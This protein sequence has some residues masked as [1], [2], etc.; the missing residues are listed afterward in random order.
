MK[1]ILI[2]LLV[3]LL[4]FSMCGCSTAI[5]L[6]FSSSPE[7]SSETVSEPVKSPVKKPKDPAKEE[8]QSEVHEEQSDTDE[9]SSA[10]SEEQ[11]D[12][13]EEPSA[14]NDESSAETEK[15][16][17]D[18]S[19]VSLRQAMV[20]T[21]ETFAVA[22]FGFVEE[23]SGD[24]AF[25]LRE[26]CPS[27]TEDLPFLTQIPEG[28]V[29]GE[30]GEMYCIVPAD[31]N[32]TVAVNLLSQD[33]EGNVFPDKVLYRKEVGEPIVLLCNYGGFYPDCVVYIT[34][35]EG[36][37]T[38]FYPQLNSYGICDIPLNE[39]LEPV[40]FDFSDYEAVEGPYFFW[41]SQGWL[42]PLKAGLDNTSWTLYA[43][44]DDGVEATLMLELLEDG[45]ASFLWLLDGE[46]REFI[47]DWYVEEYGDA[48]L[49][50]LDLFDGKEYFYEQFP[51]LIDLSG[52]RTA[53]FEGLE[54]T[55]LPVGEGYRDPMTFVY[56]VG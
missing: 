17:P 50:T 34:D 31:E 25:A 8:E 40:G 13:V 30:Y 28:N 35:S 47:G 42:P 43:Y 27:L 5:S 32:A 19:L 36:K 37:S 44:R 16:V 56:A 51:V 46:R 49:L 24:I 20:G 15:M 11:S 29:I 45:T 52:T 26:K 41:K 9:E 2:A 18:P 48:A 33:E 54:G 12:A 10:V 39:N 53:F 7:E 55:Y 4:V 22:Y 38:E 23:Y 3:M 21:S 6:L 14:T 1:K